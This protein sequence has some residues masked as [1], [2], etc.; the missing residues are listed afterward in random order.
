MSLEGV[1]ACFFVGCIL[2]IPGLTASKP[3]IFAGVTDGSAAKLP[4]KIHSPIDHPN[5]G[6]FPE[7]VRSILSQS[8][9]E[10]TAQGL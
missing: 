10:H 8:T 1:A 2:R 3:A 7:S 6:V 9:K 5:Y 4:A